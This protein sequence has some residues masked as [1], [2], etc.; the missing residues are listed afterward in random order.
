ML[1]STNLPK[2]KLPP[3]FYFYLEVLGLRPQPSDNL[4]PR[5]LQHP[6]PASVCELTSDG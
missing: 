2:S 6:K 4:P 3:H 5:K 1:K